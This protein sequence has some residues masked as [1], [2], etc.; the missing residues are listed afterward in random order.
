MTSAETEHKIGG[1]PLA[2]AGVPGETFDFTVAMDANEII[3]DG[4]HDPV[5]AT[6]AETRWPLQPASGA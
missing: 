1:D 6:I 2:V 3:A 4:V 5:N